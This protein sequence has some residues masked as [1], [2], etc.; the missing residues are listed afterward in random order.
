MTPRGSEILAYVRAEPGAHTAAELARARGW[1]ERLT[2]LEAAALE[3]EGLLLPRASGLLRVRRPVDS[4]SY[5]GVPA[6]RQ[7]ERAVLM[8]LAD[9]HDTVVNVTAAFGM[10]PRRVRRAWTWLV[11]DGWGWRLGALVPVEIA[12]GA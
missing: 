10:P 3:A 1:G 6:A 12:P 7:D 8:A 2:Q 4:L 5:R 11:S 9:G